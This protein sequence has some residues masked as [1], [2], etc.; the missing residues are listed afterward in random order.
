MVQSLCDFGVG[1]SWSTVGRM[2]GPG[3][4]GGSRSWDGGSD[5]LCLTT[6]RIARRIRTR[7]STGVRGLNVEAG[8]RPAYMAI[9]GFMWV[10]MSLFTLN[11]FSMAVSRPLMKAFSVSV[12]DLIRRLKSCIFRRLLAA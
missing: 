9:A 1:G 7:N 4:S 12:A 3:V 11:L 8:S 6:G 5:R 2:T 10:S